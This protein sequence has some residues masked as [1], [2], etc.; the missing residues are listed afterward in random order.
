[1]VSVIYKR[2]VLYWILNTRELAGFSV[3][4]LADINPGTQL[5]YIVA[6]YISVYPVAISMRNSNIY[7]VIRR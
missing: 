7:Q 5:V 4:N 3:I 1:M 2:H 6:M